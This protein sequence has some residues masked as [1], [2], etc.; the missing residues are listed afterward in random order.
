MQAVD[1]IENIYSYRVQIESKNCIVYKN[2]DV[3]TQWY[4]TESK[5]MAVFISVSD[6]AKLYNNNNNNK[7]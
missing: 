1:F 7:L 4:S 3:I 5:L 6:F 2:S